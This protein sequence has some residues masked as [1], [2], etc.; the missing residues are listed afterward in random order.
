LPQVVVVC[1]TRVVVV[2]MVVEVEAVVTVVVGEVV[3]VVLGD[4]GMGLVVEVGVDVV[5]PDE[6]LE[7][8]GCV[9]VTMGLVAGG[10]CVVEEPTP[11]GNGLAGVVAGG[12]DTPI[13]RPGAGVATGP[14]ACSGAPVPSSHMRSRVCVIVGVGSVCP[15]PSPPE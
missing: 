6:V 9:V 12:I 15:V 2:S 10:L 11:P 1:S 14:A 4:V 3:V 8:D 13:R 7:I 5:G